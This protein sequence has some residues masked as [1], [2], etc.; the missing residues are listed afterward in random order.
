[1][2]KL[3]TIISCFILCIFTLGF[4]G[5]G[6]PALKGGPDATETVYGNGGYAVRKGDYIYYANAYS[7]KT[8]TE[9]DNKYGSETLSAI[10]RVKLNEKGLVEVDE[11][12]K[13]KNVDV[14]ARQIA[15]FDGSAIY[16]FGD[17]IY[18]ATPKTLKVKP[19]VG[20]E[21]L[22]E[23]LVSFERIKLDGTAHHTIYSINTLGSDL[24]YNFAQVGNNVCLT[25]LNEGTLKTIITN[26]SA[27][28]TIAENVTSVVFPKVENIPSNYVVSD[29][30]SHV[31]YTR[32]ATIE[33]DGYAGTMVA[34][35]KLDGSSNET[36]LQNNTVATLV[37]AK[38]GRVYFT[39]EGILYSTQDL[40]FSINTNVQ[41]S[42]NTLSSTI[43]LDDNNGTD[44]GIVGV[45]NNSI[46]YYEGL[47]NK[48]T[49]FTASSG[50][51]VTLLY[52]E[53]NN[54]F[55]TLGDNVL[56]SKQV[57]KSSYPA[58]EATIAGHIHSSNIN[59]TT[60]S[61][62][63]FDFDKNAFFYFNTVEDSNGTY[64]YLHMVKHFEVDE[65][66]KTFEQFMG[67]LDASDIKETE[68]E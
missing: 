60:N 12:G 62:T 10:Y 54:I 46:V 24:K 66:G 3:L 52:V 25:V 44:I 7:T 37:E 64:S 30:D 48:H 56:Y 28:K 45:L 19:E 57:Y 67:E 14:L 1:M 47:N 58:D 63:A 59:I 2:K 34:K 8:L 29:F 9:N 65:F 5:C 15:G 49:L 43:I 51:T 32:T 18:Y 41:Y 42:Y 4:V 35:T 68:E 36:P 39:E 6:T 16:I 50:T 21:E 23:G 13:V 20:Q 11:D 53:N 40:T 27:T 55:Y 38:N 26:N 22:L 33:K 17:Y 31:Y 61:A